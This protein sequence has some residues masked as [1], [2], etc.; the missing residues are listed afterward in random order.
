MF[1]NPKVDK[2]SKL[3]V[4]MGFFAVASA[5]SAPADAQSLVARLDAEKHVY[6]TLMRCD[7]LIKRKA[8][9]EALPLLTKLAGEQDGKY[10]AQIYYQIALCK[11]GMKQFQ[12]AL[13]AAQKAVTLDEKDADIVYLEALISR[14]MGEYDLCVDYLNQYVQMDISADKRTRA[15]V[16][17]KDTRAF[18]NVTA[19]DKLMRKKKFSEAVFKLREA[20]QL[21]PT[22]YSV[23]VHNNLV[24]ALRSDSK[25]SEAIE[26]SKAALKLDPNNANTVY[27]VALSYEGLGNYSE[28]IAVLKKYLQMDIDINDRSSAED[29]L[30]ALNE[31]QK[32]A[33][34]AHSRG[35]DYF[36]ENKKEDGLSYWEPS[37]MPLKI[38]LPDQ[39]TARGYTKQFDSFITN[40]FD[41]WSEASGRKLS[42][43]VV[44]DK[45]AAD[46]VV[47][48]TD[49]SL[50]H[51]TSGH[52]FRVSGL[53]SSQWYERKEHNEYKQAKIQIMTV[54]PWNQSNPVDPAEC[55]S[56]CMH[57]VGH[58][59]GLRHSACI[60]DVMYFRTSNAQTG[61]PTS[62]DSKTLAYIY[63]AHPKVASVSRS[64]GGINIKYLPPPCFRPPKLPG[65]KHLAPPLFTPPPVSTSRLRPP[66]YTP[67]P[68]SVNRT[69]EGSKP[70]VEDAGQDKG[71]EM[72]PNDRKPVVPLF[73]PPPM[74]KREPVPQPKPKEKITQPPLF[75]PDPIKK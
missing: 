61:M 43:K 2:L 10:S 31:D 26:E 56:V 13:E 58:A 11:R 67:P 12:S 25:F 59:L 36:D 60:A 50:E 1:P 7:Q 44:K 21:D 35:P 57:E 75:I 28:A 24:V 71:K 62:R 4:A 8:F 6:A 55:A 17:S 63:L 15:K 29:Y 73:T 68:L 53:T 69:D 38:Y 39:V 14:D 51:G 66:M 9:P 49:G 72:V 18:K 42:Y 19:A 74:K 52:N 45:L 34:S 32:S 22:P 23:S 20:A 27:A 46:I 41:V 5:Q 40:A 30:E 33:R 47:A 64:P 70:D 48:W 37:R 54:D 3:M 65:T 16:F